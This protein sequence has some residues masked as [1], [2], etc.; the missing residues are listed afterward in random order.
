M[1]SDLG[2]AAGRE[3]AGGTQHAKE[4]RGVPLHPSGLIRGRAGGADPWLA[5]GPHPDPAWGS[6]LPKWPKINS[7]WRMEMSLWPTGESFSEIGFKL[8]YTS[9]FMGT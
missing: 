9:N 6:P 7:V 4:T 5:T 8:H 2:R 3:E 1:W